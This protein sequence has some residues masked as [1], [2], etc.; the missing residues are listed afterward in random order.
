[1]PDFIFLPN[2]HSNLFAFFFGVDVEK[3][4]DRTLD[5][6]RINSESRLRR[7]STLAR[8]YDSFNGTSG[9]GLIVLHH[10]R[11]ILCLRPL[12]FFRCVRIHEGRRSL[13]KHSPPGMTPFSHFKL[14]E[15]MR[16]EVRLEAGD[17][18]FALEDDFLGKFA[19]EFDEEFVLEE[20]FAV[21]LGGVDFLRLGED[22]G[23]DG[24]IEPVHVDVGVVG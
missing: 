11:C 3:P 9:R 22:F 24:F 13:K 10:A 15:E 18:E 8:T 21:P 7:L 6:C 2:S 16:W 12:G 23:G 4:F 5:T 20:E 19:V 14:G 17:E 1:M